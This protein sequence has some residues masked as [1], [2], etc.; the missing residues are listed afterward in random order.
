MDDFTDGALSRTE[1]MAL[2][3]TAQFGHLA[4]TRQAL[5]TVV[6]AYYVVD[7]DRVVIHASS[8]LDP[9]A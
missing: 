9:V 7:E 8:G 1:C 6:P 2:L 5:P 4:L 3:A